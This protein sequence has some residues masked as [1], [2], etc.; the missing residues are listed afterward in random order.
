L[1]RRRRVCTHKAGDY[2]GNLILFLVMLKDLKR[3]AKV[4]KRR[5]RK[6]RAKSDRLNN[7]DCRTKI[8]I[9][10]NEKLRVR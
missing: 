2:R 10:S 5:A 8:V 3:R 9:N 1:R 7:T 6:G 4:V